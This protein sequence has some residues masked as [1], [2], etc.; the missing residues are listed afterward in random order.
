MLQCRAQCPQWR[1]QGLEV[2]SAPLSIWPD[3]QS[4]KNNFWL[5]GSLPRTDSVAPKT[6]SHA[7]WHYT[8]NMFCY[9]V[10]FFRH[11]CSETNT[12]WRKYKD[13]KDTDGT[14]MGGIKDNWGVFENKIFW[15]GTWF[16]F[17]SFLYKNRK[18]VFSF[19]NFP[20]QC[21]FDNS[22]F[23]YKIS[24]HI[25]RLKSHCEVKLQVSHL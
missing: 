14:I 20:I 22:Y 3:M 18:S 19:E 4:F 9:P 24:K 17:F 2:C 21:R 12:T 11:L 25:S 15:P 13:L 16:Y 10:F 5:S 1:S 6:M 23:Q 7:V 8:P